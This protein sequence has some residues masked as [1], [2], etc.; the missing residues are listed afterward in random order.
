MEM[1]FGKTGN[2]GQ[3]GIHVDMNALKKG[4][5]KFVIV[6]VPSCCGPSPLLL[7]TGERD[8]RADLCY[9]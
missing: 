2:L 1:E 4:E 8:S 3:D 9:A 5:V 6:A 7:A